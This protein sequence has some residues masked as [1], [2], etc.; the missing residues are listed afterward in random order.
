MSLLQEQVRERGYKGARVV[1]GIDRRTVA[2]SAKSGQLTNR[3]RERLER[4]LR[5]GVGSAAAEQQERNDKLEEYLDKM[6]SQLKGLKENL[7]SG[8]KVLHR[9]EGRFDKMEGRVKDL[10]EHLPNRLKRLKMSLGG[11][12]STMVCSVA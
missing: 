3:V 8:L 5:Y 9:L 4:A 11:M 1:L 7:R 6:E 2:S 12:R 10:K